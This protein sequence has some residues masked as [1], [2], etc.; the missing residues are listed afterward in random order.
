[1]PNDVPTNQLTVSFLDASKE[2]ASSQMNAQQLATNGDY[3]TAVNN[4]VTGMQ[5]I[6]N[7]TVLADE[8]FLVNRRSNAVPAQPA[9]R[10]TK[11]LVSYED[12]VTLKR[13]SVTV[14]TLDTSAVVFLGQTDDIDPAGNT[15]TTDF[16]TA[17]EAIVAS[18]AGNA[19]SVVALKRVGRNN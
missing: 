9:A 18:P 7:G 8:S 3:V 4:L 19:V 6:T 14:P 15:A 17:F 10:E 16:V 5:G 12:N 1:M 11:L 13:Y 2:G